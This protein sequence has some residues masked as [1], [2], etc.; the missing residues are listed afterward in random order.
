MIDADPDLVSGKEK[1]GC[2]DKHPGSAT[3]ATVIEKVA[4]N[5]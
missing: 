5:I 1:V 2:R 4:K 3:L